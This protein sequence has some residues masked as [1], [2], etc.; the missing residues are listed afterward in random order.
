MGMDDERVVHMKIPGS[1][2]AWGPWVPT[3]NKSR[4]CLLRAL[5]IARFLDR[6]R[7]ALFLGI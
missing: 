3:S 2:L 4:P 5:R 1:V 7:S 6:K